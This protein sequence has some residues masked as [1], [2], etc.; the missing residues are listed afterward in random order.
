MFRFVLVKFLNDSLTQRISCIVKDGI[1]LVT[2][3]DSPIQG[4]VDSI[5]QRPDLRL[6][7]KRIVRTSRKGHK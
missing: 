3:W 2:I 6:T 1:L 4:K 5:S 7:S